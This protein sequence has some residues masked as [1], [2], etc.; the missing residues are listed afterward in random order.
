MSAFQ[1][2]EQARNA[3]AERDRRDG[4]QYATHASGRCAGEHGLCGACHADEL[5]EMVAWARDQGAMR[6]PGE[7]LWSFWQRIGGR[8]LDTWHDAAYTVDREQRAALGKAV[9]P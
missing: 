8:F 3:R 1:L 9:G 7:T 2:S 6:L 4:L 5:R